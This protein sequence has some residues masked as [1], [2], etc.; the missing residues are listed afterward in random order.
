MTAVTIVSRQDALASFPWRVVRLCVVLSAL[1]GGAAAQPVT[2]I[3]AAE[4]TC[5]TCT[6]ELTKVATLGKANDSVLLGQI[7]GVIAVNSRGEYFAPASS[8]F[9]VAVYDSVGRLLRAVGQRGPGPGEFRFIT[10]IHVGAG[11]SILIADARN[12]LQLFTPDLR[13]HRAIRVPDAG[14]FGLALVRDDWEMIVQTLPD[15]LVVISP[16]GVVRDTIALGPASRS[17]RCRTCDIRHLSSASGEGQ[18]WS[19]ISNRYDIELLD[20]KGAVHRTLS[21]RPDWFAPWDFVREGPGS[22]RRPPLPRVHAVR[23]GP[24]GLLWVSVRVPDANWTYSPPT[25]ATHAADDR[26]IDVMLAV[27]DP[28]TGELLAERRL[29]GAI[30]FVGRRDLMF[31]AAE[32]EDGY[33][34]ADIWRVSL[35]RR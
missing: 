20:T 15:R 28:K 13:Y 22:E 8:Q 7:V 4:P 19:T 16:T 10:D 24:D 11:D 5:R 6:I 3:L 35:K 21:R 32:H 34:F 1:S 12:N 31:T 33:V 9:Q 2:T 18:F 27:I 17:G 14:S 25:V 29:P 23:E 26:E 30:G